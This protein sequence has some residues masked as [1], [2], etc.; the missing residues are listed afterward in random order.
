MNVDLAPTIL[1]MAGIEIPEHMDGR[2]LLKLTKNARYQNRYM[3]VNVIEIYFCL[4]PDIVIIP[5]QKF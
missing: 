2:S 3:F 1:D 4:S 5:L